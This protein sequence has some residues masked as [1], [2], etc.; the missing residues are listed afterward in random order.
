VEVKGVKL[1]AQRLEGADPKSLRGISD[2]IKAEL[3]SGAVFLAAPHA[4]KLSFVLAATEDLAGRGFDAGSVAKKFSAAHGGSAGGRAGFA[5][6]GLP[7]ADW[8]RLVES[9]SSLL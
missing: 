9:L 8:D 5:Q 1:C 2:K 4:G 3:G 7:D 6:G